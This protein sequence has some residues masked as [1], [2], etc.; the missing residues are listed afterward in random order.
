MVI[1]P[2]KKLLFE[3]LLIAAFVVAVSI[4]VSL[5]LALAGTRNA[6]ADLQWGEIKPALPT[7]ILDINDREIT[8]FFGEEKRDIISITDVP[9]SLINALL[10]R[11]DQHFYSHHGFRFQSILRAAFNIVTGQ[12]VS[13]ASTITQQLAGKLFADRTEFS[14]KRKLVELWW[15][16]QLERQYTKSEILEMYMNE[17]PFGAGTQGVEAASKFFFGHGVKDITLAESAMLVIQLARP[18]FYSPIKYPDRA[19]KMQKKILDDM[20]RLKYCSKEEADASLQDFW[21]R[22]DYTR[23]SSA[24]PY[25]ER[26][27][28]ARYF[29]EYV[30]SQ[31]EDMLF[32]SVNILKDGLVVH[33]TLNLD[34]QKEADRIMGE[35]ID[36]INEKYLKSSGNSASY[37]NASFLPLIDMITSTFN[38]D[39]LQYRQS[40]AKAKWKSYYVKNVNPV[41]DLVS[42][43]F[44]LEG[45]QNV[46]SAG[47]LSAQFT[48]RR[49][50]VQGALISL[51]SHKGYILAMVGGREWKSTDQFNRAASGQVEPGSAFKPMYY[52]AAIDSRKFTAATMILDK[53][54]VFT[55]PDGRPYEPQ[56]YKGQFHGRVLLRDALAESMNIPSLVVLDT[57]GF[58]AAI[59]RASR[60]LGITD[61]AEIVRVFPRYYPLGL[62]VLP[63]SPLQMARAY[64]VFANQGREVVPITIRYIEDRNGKIILEPEKELRAQQARKGDAAQIMSPQTAYIMTSILESTIAEGSLQGIT[65]ILTDL[66]KRPMA[67]KTGTTQNW[68]DAWTVGFTPQI[69]TA[70]WFGFDQGNR[71]L[72]VNLTGALAAG[73][74]WARYMK[75][76]H[77]G[78]PPEKFPRPES[79]LVTVNVSA[80]SGLLPTKYSKKVIPEIFLA[81]TEPKTFDEI[82]EYE[83][84]RG[85][86]I[87]DNLMKS[88]LGGGMLPSNPDVN[89]PPLDDK[90]P[91]SGTPDSGNPLLD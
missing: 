19:M 10:T 70:V 28:K 45:A 64:A 8:Q 15:A 51:D 32:G 91:D 13:G 87:Q 17:M 24:S 66:N 73:P 56:N 49:T 43:L 60:M 53:P 77:K 80:S 41:V 88:Q 29:S 78:V 82:D 37:A 14:L 2:R 16:I 20:V 75:A 1:L 42:S 68:S 76:I 38:I 7:K 33:T 31:L 44:S 11:E 81:G 21:A 6:R 55:S 26:E 71:S 23:S 61:P 47:Y 85:Q 40:S 3:I 30:R 50:Q 58:D 9:Q 59:Q 25:F 5:G 22:H 90:A 12:F 83:S 79:G 69:T 46:A 72:G 35:G 62:G 63:V 52:S 48:A 4:G 84:V 36:N 18:G 54:V 65:G 74:I 57:V 67:A 39:G 89:L 34:Y 27:D 86:D